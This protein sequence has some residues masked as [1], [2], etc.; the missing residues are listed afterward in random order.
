[1]SDWTDTNQE[2]VADAL[3]GLESLA[4]STL[5]GYTVQA[6]DTLSKIAK[7]TLSDATQWPAL[8]YINAD[9]IADVSKLKVGQ[10]LR[11]PTTSK[12]AT[13]ILSLFMAH[14]TP[15]I[16]SVDGTFNASP[17][18]QQ[19]L[20]HGSNFQVGM[21]PN[22]GTISYIS[23]S[24]CTWVVTLA[25]AGASTLVFTNPNGNSSNTYNFDVISGTV[26]P[27]IPAAL[28]VVCPGTITVTSLTN[29]G[30]MVT[31]P[32][33]TATGGTAPLVTTTDVASGSTF[34][35]GTTTVHVT[36]TDA[37]GLTATC[38]F[39]VVVNYTPAPVPTPPS[40]LLISVPAN[41]SVISLDNLGVVVTYSPAT[42]SG[43]VAPYTITYSKASGQSFAVGVTVVTCTATDAQAT[44]AVGTFTVTVTYTPAPQPVPPLTLTPPASIALTTSTQATQAVTYSTPSASG[45]VAPYAITS[46]PSSGSQFAIGI[47]TVTCRVT[48]AVG[49]TATATFTVTITYIPAPTPSAPS[50]P[51]NLLVTPGDTQIRATWVASATAST[52]TL[53]RGT[54]AGVYGTTAATGIAGTSYLDTGLTNGVTY[55]YTVYAVNLGGTSGASN[56]DHATPVAVVTLPPPAPGPQPPPPVPTG[57]VITINAGGNFQGAIDAA[58]PG[59]VIQ[60][61]AGATFIGDIL[62]PVK[63]GSEYITIRSSAPASVLPPAGT[64]TGPQYSGYMPKFRPSGLSTGTAIETRDTSHHWRWE[65]CEF[66]PASGGQSVNTQLVTFGSYAG[67]GQTTQTTSGTLPHHLILDRCYLHDDNGGICKRGVLLNANYIQTINSYL[68]GFRGVGQ[69]TQ[70]MLGF[71]GEGPFLIDNNYIA[72]ATENVL[73]GGADPYITNLIPSDITVTNNY[74]TKPPS[75]NPGDASYAGTN[76][77]VKNVFELKNAQRVTIDRNI[78]ENAWASGQAGYL[79][80]FTGLNDGGLGTWCTV[81]SIAFTNNVVR[82]GNGGIQISGHNS[83]TI[84]ANMPPAG[85]DITV[86]NN[87]LYNINEVYGNGTPLGTFLQIGNDVYNVTIDHNTVQQVNSGQYGILITGASA[88]TNISM[89]NNFFWRGLYGVFA[90]GAFSEGSSSIN[91]MFTPGG[92]FNKHV[93]ANTGGTPPAYPTGTT[94]LNA[95]DWNAQFVDPINHNYTLKAAS[96]YKNAGTDGLDIGVNMSALPIGP[97]TAPLDAH[98]VSLSGSDTTGDGSITRPWLTISYGISKLATGDTLYIRGGTYTGTANCI[99]DS[100]FTASGLSWTQPITVSGYP[101]ETVEIQPPYPY[102][103][104]SLSIA[105]PVRSYLIFQDLTINMGPQGVNWPTTLI[106]GGEGPSGIGVSGRNHHNRFQR[107]TVKNNQGTGVQFSDYAGNSPF[108]EVLNCSVHDNGQYPY[109]EAGSGG[110]GHNQGYGFYIKSS[111]N[112]FE[113]NDVYNNHGYGFHFYSPNSNPN[114]RNIIRKNRIHDN[115]S[116]FDGVMDPQGSNT[117]YGIIASHGTDIQIYDNLIYGNR[118]GIQVVGTST[119]VYNNTIYNNIYVG[120]GLDVYPGAVNAVVRNNISYGNYSDYMDNGTGTTADHNL[121]TNPSFVSA[122]A[123]NFHLQAGS[124]A[125]GA[126]V[127]VGAVTD[128]YDGVARPNPPD[129]GAFQFV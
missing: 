110:A 33:P 121:T 27:P 109:G 34:A 31:Y 107:L 22:R 103:G 14:R 52:Y 125:R 87:L 77:L 93:I 114:D 111:D 76:W 37:V 35:V 65:N 56:E 26:N 25:D 39:N 43:G 32:T 50:A 66:L 46:S 81:K 89:T 29:T 122:G 44:S 58:Q 8:Y 84:P 94:F 117:N 60:C 6:G 83:Y 4:K 57:N 48:D 86:K 102:G 45:G 36:V 128:D 80:L 62:L 9:R 98:Y 82:N 124:T 7:A 64:R 123:A 17:A 120:A 49:S 51:T 127:T 28:S 72:A 108:N 119:L 105:N 78:F 100:Q 19:H 18:P 67:A 59:D 79:V 54:A 90:G 11:V 5:K 112:L 88:L 74:M 42:V 106:T 97:F 23:K 12:S 116:R 10:V 20:V 75:W 3:I 104:I 61:Q 71:N 68:F 73:F 53:K 2:F 126:G 95:A 129:I 70:G 92:V 38:S 118:G 99:I 55:Y 16:T 21:V 69:E 101:G 47:T 30:T 15:S 24:K 63:S 13:T 96:V 1:M 40:P 115:G 113:G 85:H 41:V 91:G